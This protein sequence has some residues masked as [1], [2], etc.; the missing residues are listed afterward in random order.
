MGHKASRSELRLSLQERESLDQIR[1][2]L[3][4]QGMKVSDEKVLLVVLQAAAK[5]PESELVRLIRESMSS[6]DQDRQER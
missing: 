5:L 1:A 6:A 3:A 4:T 2:L